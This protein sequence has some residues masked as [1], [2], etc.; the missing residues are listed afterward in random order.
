VDEEEAIKGKEKG[1]KK[2]SLAGGEGVQR[3]SKTTRRHFSPGIQKGKAV[4]GRVES[5]GIPRA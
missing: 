1:G 2:A 3:W 5:L 4:W